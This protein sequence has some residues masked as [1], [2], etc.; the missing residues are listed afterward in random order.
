MCRIE[1]DS[2]RPH[3]F[4][5]TI[6]MKEIEDITL[7]KRIVS[8]LQTGSKQSCR[9]LLRESSRLERN[10]WVRAM[11]NQDWR[12]AGKMHGVVANHHDGRSALKLSEAFVKAILHDPVADSIPEMIFDGVAGIAVPQT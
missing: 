11:P 9:T 4:D 7:A 8:L 6:V 5:F 1:A 12:S 3:Q 2:A 10:E